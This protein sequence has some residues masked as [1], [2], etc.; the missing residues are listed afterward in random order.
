MSN[1][2]AKILVVDDDK[3]LRDT[4]VDLLEL[5]D[6]NVSEAGSGKECRELVS[7]E[8]FHIIL[9]DYSLG[10]ATGLELIK[11]IR[12]FNV[13]TQ[14]IMITA[15]ASLDTAVKAIQESVYDFL[16]KP[17]DFDYL[18][19]TIKKALDKYYLEKSNADL[20][21]KLKKTNEDLRFLNNMKSKFFSMVSH[22]LS[23]YIMTLKMG[24]DMLLKT[25]ETDENQ[26]QKVEYIKESINQI[27]RLI[28]DL[29][30]WAYIEQGK[31]RLERGYFE[32]CA[33]IRSVVENF[34]A[35]TDEK[36][37]DL[38]ITHCDD[39]M[40]FADE[41]RIKQVLYN[42]LENSLR[43]TSNGGKIE[44]EVNKDTDSTIKIS[45]K[46]D[47]E[48]IDPNDVPN[49]FKSFYQ[50]EGHTK[51]KLGLGLSISQ[52]VILNHGGK[53]WAES[54]GNGKGATFHFTLDEAKE[55]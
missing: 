27:S 31:L 38:L 53:I 3:N 50:V 39:V 44:V 14:I 10:D 52:D 16:V 30:D 43:H 54:K 37:I 13:E 9:M 51:G 19:N 28:S 35:R 47:G 36:D 17:V 23:N 2:E 42:L 55:E 6:Y 21:E 12:S 15:H 18:K 45:V 7:Q 11:E 20:L 4:L 8:F 25:I 5:E 46:D 29:V 40:V 33:L 41:K 49:L 48:G 24:F 32:F 1:G 26:N 22:D 34:K